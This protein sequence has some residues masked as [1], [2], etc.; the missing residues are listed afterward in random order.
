MA[1]KAKE[2]TSPLTSVAGVFSN[3]QLETA[4]DKLA[5]NAMAADPKGKTAWDPKPG[6][7]PH[8]SADPIN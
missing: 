4:A 2:E 7:H 6:I 3:V 8:T 5:D 1:S